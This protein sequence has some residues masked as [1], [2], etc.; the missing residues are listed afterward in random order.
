MQKPIIG[1][2]NTTTLAVLVGLLAAISGYLMVP[3]KSDTKQPSAQVAPTPS[4]KR[5]EDCYSRM[6]S[7]LGNVPT[8]QRDAVS[9]QIPNICDTPVVNK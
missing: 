6:W 4:Q 1:A 3:S 8:A 2:P 5:R 7:H 9:S